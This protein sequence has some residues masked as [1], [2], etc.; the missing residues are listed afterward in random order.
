[1]RAVI[2][3]KFGSPEYLTLEDI[4]R[5]DPK[6]NEVLIR[7]KATSV[8]SWDWDWVIGRPYIYRPLFGLLKPRMAILGCDVAGVIEAVGH[9]VKDFNKGDEVFGDL[10]NQNWGGFAEYTVAR[11]DI[12]SWKPTSLSFEMA[13][14]LPQAGVLALQGL[15][16]NGPVKKEQ[17]ILIIGAGGGVGTFGIQLAVHWGARVSVV[18]AA[19]KLDRLKALGAEQAYD[20]RVT[21]LD[22]IS[23]QFD[24]IVDV[25]AS[26]PRKVYK[27]LLNPG[28]AL[29]VIGGK[30]K[31]IFN[32]AIKD[33]FSL[34]SDQRMGIVAH[35]P[36]RKEQDEL[37]QYVID[38]IIN[39]VIDE[40][41]PL[42]K[43][44]EALDR[45]GGGKVF[46][47]VIIKP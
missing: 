1:M 26:Y 12:L 11:P 8:N 17:K 7:T 35:K 36:N 29:A 21:P 46:G 34:K 28:G 32:T 22:K 41:F 45:L 16:F 31:I 20:Y 37:A 39:P 15:R 18:D 5:P 3:K 2:H 4:P 27:S 23:D 24:L 6:P 10:S 19:E 44:A 14:S 42:E 40:V 43:T 33:Y 13:S 47:K 38:G 30:P 25:I 9:D